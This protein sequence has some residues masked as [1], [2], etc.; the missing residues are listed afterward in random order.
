MRRKVSLMAILALI[1][2]KAVGEETGIPIVIEKYFVNDSSYNIDEMYIYGGDGQNLLQKILP[3]EGAALVSLPA[4]D[5]GDY[6]GFELT[7]WTINDLDSYIW[8]AGGCA[9]GDGFIVYTNDS[10]ENE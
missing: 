5:F 8:Y 9:S 4:Y 2:S 7:T 10:F 6:C 1:A 3:P